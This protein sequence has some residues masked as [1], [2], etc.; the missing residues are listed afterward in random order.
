MSLAGGLVFEC[1]VDGTRRRDLNRDRIVRFLRKAPETRLSRSGPLSVTHLRDLRS[2]MLL[3]KSHITHERVGTLPPNGSMQVDNLPGRKWCPPVLKLAGNLLVELGAAGK[4]Q[5]VTRYTNQRCTGGRPHE[6]AFCDL[7][8]GKE[9]QGNCG[10][11]EDSRC[12]RAA[13]K[14]Q[15][16]KWSIRNSMRAAHRDWLRVLIV[17]PIRIQSGFRHICAEYRRRLRPSGP[18]G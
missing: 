2:E 18:A 13:D 6:Q 14:W 16:R 11:S 3:A 10:G 12:D 9:R 5:H 4:R 8:L 1:D 15:Y 17:S 7:P